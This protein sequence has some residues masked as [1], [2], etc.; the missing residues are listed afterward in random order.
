MNSQKKKQKRYIG[1]YC[2]KCG[3]EL[4]A[5]INKSGLCHLCIYKDDNFRRK[6]SNSLKGNIA[7]NKGI[8]KYKSY[9][10]AREEW[11][12]RRMKRYYGLSVKDRLP[13]LLRT[14]IRNGLL[15]HKK[16]SQPTNELLGCSYDYFKKY[17][18]NLFIR[19]MSWDNFGNKTESWNIDHIIP[20]SKFDLTIK[21]ERL[22]AFN[23]KNCQ[24]MWASDNYRKKDKLTYLSMVIK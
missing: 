17:I 20:I 24:P 4:S 6:I 12:R 8:S 13:D 9:K 22:K 23:Y 15:K 16:K 5:K 19:G 21:E 11:Q 18:E 14:R 7:W 10:Q 1:I 2:K 3:K